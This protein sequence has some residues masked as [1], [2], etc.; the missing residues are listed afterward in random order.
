[1]ESWLEGVAYGAIANLS[2][3]LVA[4]ASCSQ[5]LEIEPSAYSWRLALEQDEDEDDGLAA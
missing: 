2:D 3:P 5:S 1:M 4:K